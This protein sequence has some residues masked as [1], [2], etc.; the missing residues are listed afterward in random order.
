MFVYLLHEFFRCLNRILMLFQF[1]MQVALQ[2]VLQLSTLLIEVLILLS[3]A[4]LSEGAAS[5][6]DTV[7]SSMVM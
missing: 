4:F 2:L 3:G 7:T 1:L 6:S 5:I